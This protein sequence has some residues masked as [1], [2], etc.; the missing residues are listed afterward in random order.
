MT[1][2]VII[3]AGISGLSCG[4]FIS[5]KT[6]NFL[7]LESKDKLGG[8]IQTN[9][10]QN[11][12]C[13][14]GPN[15]VLLNNEAT[16]QII[17]DCNLFERIIY[18]SINNAKNRF[19]FNNNKITKIP[20]TPIEFIKTSLLSINSKFKLFF[21]FLVPRHKKNDTV[22][23]FISKRFGK[24]FHDKLVVPFITGIYAGNTK[25]MSAKHSLKNLW[26]YEQK[27]GS[28]TKGIIQNLL[29]KK[30]QPKSFNF[31]NGLSELTLK[32]G[33]NLKKSIR[34][35]SNVSKI[36]KIEKGYEISLENEEKIYCKKLITTVPSYVLMHLID[37]SILINELKKI[38][39]NPIDVFHFGLDKKNIKNKYNGFG[40]LTKPEDKKNYLGIL[41]N[42]DIFNHVS[43][44][45]KNLY[46]VLVGGENQKILC[47]KN[48]MELQDIISEEIK[49]L[50]GYKGE[51]D[52]IK[53][54]RW[55]NGIP[56]YTMDQ[57]ELISAVRGFELKNNDFFITGNY[58]NGVSVSDCI[59]KSYDIVKRAF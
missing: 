6:N 4:H 48:I 24:E 32:I 59:Q 47:K 33:E 22:F 51:I 28:I 43:P 14:Y 16:K 44:I 29:R 23:N 40:V 38:K 37:D 9:I 5:K 27:Y 58:F 15:T 12:I 10:E 13:E 1:D 52:F 31:P 26:N 3:G 17:S 45:N 30:S 39:Y 50:F 7:I 54:Y 25:R 46:T 35:N 55:R 57:E 2:V 20:L 56:Q 11:Y 34:F 41:F 19:V 53:N 18:P 8:I 21:E 42:S 49:S 36:K